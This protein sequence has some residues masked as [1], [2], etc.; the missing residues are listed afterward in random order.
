MLSGTT[1]VEALAGLLESIPHTSIRFLPSLHAKVYIADETEAVVTSAN[2]T[3]SGLTKN[4]EYG[5]VFSDIPLVRQIKKDVLDYAGLGSPIEYP[6]LKAFAAVVKEVGGAQTSAQR[7]LNRRARK[8][9][10]KVLYSAQSEVLRARA[11]GRAPHAIFAEAILYL[12]KMGPATTEELHRKIQAIHPDLCDDSIDRVIDGKHFGK[13]W[14][15]AVR[16]AQQHLKKE[17]RIELI[18]QRW[19]IIGNGK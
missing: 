15:H 19:R 2:M 6:Q 18:D 5:A 14:K 3:S 7:T 10:E 13:R 17:G 8:E 16:T 4:F 9:F 12:L 1:D 11:A